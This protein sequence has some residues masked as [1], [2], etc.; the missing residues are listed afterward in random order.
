[1]IFILG[2]E[3]INDFCQLSNLLAHLVVEIRKHSGR[4]GCCGGGSAGKETGREYPLQG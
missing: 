2:I 4:L 3:V 1:M